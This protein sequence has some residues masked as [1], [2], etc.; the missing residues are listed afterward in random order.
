MTVNIKY[1]ASNPVLP[2][3]TTVKGTPLTNEE[4]DGNFKSVKD[5]VES[6]QSVS[7]VTSV[8][9]S[10]PLTSSGGP[11][12]TITFTGILAP[13]NGGT[14][15]A[16]VNGIMKGNGSSNVTAAVAGTDYTT[17]SGTETLSNKTIQT[18]N[19][20]AGYTEGVYALSGTAV[21]LLPSNGT[22]QTW[23]L[24]AALS[25]VSTT[26]A[27]TSGQSITLMIAATTNT[28][29]WSAI[30]I[31]WLTSTAT[32]PS[33]NSSA[34]TIIQLWKVGSAFYGVSINAR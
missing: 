8:A 30:P 13:A 18:P 20:P 16:G 2:T 33:L 34:Y 3:E 12:P 4:I 28:I 14:G 23:T 27:W 17:P 22:I 24:S 29:N 11:T 1:R 6:L 7:Y 10:S 32:A 19:L 26:T 25:S 21:V 15:V 5:A 31:V 9:A